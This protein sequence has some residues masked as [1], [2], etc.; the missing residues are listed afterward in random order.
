MNEYFRQPMGLV[1]AG[2]GAFGS[3]QIAAVHA[4]AQSGMVFDTVLGVSAGALTGASYF[5]GR[6]DEALER[7]RSIENQRMLRLAPRLFPLTLCSGKPLADFIGAHVDDESAKK[8]ARCR[9]IVVS[10]CL[11][12]GR[13]I[14]AT[15]APGGKRWDGTLSQHL[16]ASCAIPTVFPPVVTAYRGETMTLVDGGVPAKEPMNFAELAHCKDVIIVEMLSLAEKA[17]RRRGLLQRLNEGRKRGR[18]LMNEGIDS[19]KT[20][21][22]PPRLF[23]LHPSKSLDFEMLSFK[24]AHIL[25]SIDRGIADAL[26]FI[27]EPERGRIV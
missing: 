8:A 22:K 17:L 15:F 12:A 7:W 18:N 20:L 27:A 10:T 4:L 21:K 1:L 26:A 3:W 2:G 11:K 14:Y 9:L 16:I 5:M 24:S 19:L 6:L 13:P 23:H 25:A